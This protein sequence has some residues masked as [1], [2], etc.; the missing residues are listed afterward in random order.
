MAL[1]CAEYTQ[2]KP[3]QI[4]FGFM[5]EA[6]YKRQTITGFIAQNMHC[7]KSFSVFLFQKLNKVQVLKVLFL[8]AGNR[9]EE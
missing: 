1:L 9:D 8:F 3:Y 2:T 6:K 4:A 5:V 7:E